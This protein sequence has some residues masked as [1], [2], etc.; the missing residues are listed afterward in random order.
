MAVVLAALGL[1]WLLLCINCVPATAIHTRP[2]T[3][4]GVFLTIA[5]LEG[6]LLLSH[7]AVGLARSK[8]F[9]NHKA[10]AASDACGRVG[11]G[12][13]VREISRTDALDAEGNVAATM[14]KLS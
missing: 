14:V 3:K 12:E 7:E 1:D 6:L 11:R 5:L 8:R 13:Y 4:A 9:M 2:L 10:G